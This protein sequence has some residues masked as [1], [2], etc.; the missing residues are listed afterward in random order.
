M[1]LHCFYLTHVAT[2]FFHYWYGWNAHQFVKD[3]VFS[4]LYYGCVYI[5]KEFMEP[6]LQ[7]FSFSIFLSSLE[8]LMALLMTALFR[9]SFCLF[10]FTFSVTHQNAFPWTRVQH[11]QSCCMYLFIYIWMHSWHPK[12]S[13]SVTSP[14]CTHGRVSWICSSLSIHPLVYILNLSP[15]A[16]LQRHHI[17]I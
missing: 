6:L 8:H 2:A 11:L 1:L 17:Q 14:A 4:S 10:L 7:L 5:I 13:V 15:Q 12:N 16:E 3:T 9:F